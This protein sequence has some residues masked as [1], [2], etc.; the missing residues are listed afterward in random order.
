ML[1]NTMD[2]LNEQSLG[3]N[4]LHKAFEILS[5]FSSLNIANTILWN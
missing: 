1:G 3:A 2:F 5:C 4:P